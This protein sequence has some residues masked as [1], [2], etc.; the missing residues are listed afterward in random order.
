MTIFDDLGA[1]QDR[2][3]KILNGLD[4][5][6]WESA[7]GARGWTIADVVVHPARSEEAAAATATHGNLR[8]GRGVPPGA[9]RV[10]S[11]AQARPAGA[12][13]DAAR[14]PGRAGAVDG[15]HDQAGHAGDDPAGRAL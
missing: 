7:S 11:R 4:E 3:E 8:G 6:Q 14:R 13:G 9:R 2:L 5:G 12:A 15:W 1:E 10:R